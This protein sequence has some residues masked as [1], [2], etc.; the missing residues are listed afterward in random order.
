MNMVYI[1]LLVITFDAF[2]FLNNQKKFKGY[3]T[4]KHYAETLKM[5]IY[6]KLLMVKIMI[7]VFLTTFL[8]F[9]L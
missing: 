8:N 6:Q 9:V 2:L 7:V 5:P 1:I 3:V 4:L